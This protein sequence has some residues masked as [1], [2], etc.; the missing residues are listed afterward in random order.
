MPRGRSPRLVALEC[1]ARILL[2]IV[3]AEFGNQAFYADVN[4]YFVSARDLSL[5]HLPYR[6]FL[7]E[8]PPLTTIALVLIPALG[9]SQEYFVL[10]FVL[11]FG[12]GL[13]Y[14]SLTYLRCAFPEKTKDITILWTVAVLPLCSFAWFRLDWI[15]VFPTVVALVA[16]ERRKPATVAIIAGVAA[17]VW[18]ATLCAIF[19]ARREWRRLGLVIAGIV[20]LCLLWYLFSPKGVSDF[21]EFRRGSGYQIES[22]PGAALLLAGVD[23]EFRYGSVIVSTGRYQWVQAVLNIFTICGGAAI[24]SATLFR[25]AAPVP[26]VASL[27]LVLLIGSRIIS[28]QYLVWLAPFVAL[29]WTQ[30]REIGYWYIASSM[31]TLWVVVQYQ[32]L[33]SSPIWV[34][35]PLMIRNLILLWMLVLFV[36][37]TFAS[38]DASNRIS[39]A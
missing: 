10:A 20:A 3:V 32:K 29:C 24:V 9:H 28:P 27:V 18:P 2:L 23:W 21:L 38:N 19:I 13:E 8:F 14:G 26:L 7:W 33:Y 6:D 22:L 39:P 31:L 37:E 36:Q 1:G 17:K 15:S 12:V 4:H 34:S 25:R 30:R 11:I 16:I 35:I 5:T